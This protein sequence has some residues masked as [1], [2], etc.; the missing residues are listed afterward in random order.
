MYSLIIESFNYNENRFFTQTELYDLQQAK[1]IFI[2]IAQAVDQ[3]YLMTLNSSMTNE[4]RNNT[5][6]NIVKIKPFNTISDAETFSSMLAHEPSEY[7]QSIRK[8][9][10][11]NNVLSKHYIID[12][13]NNVVKILSDCEEHICQ[14]FNGQCNSSGCSKVEFATSL[15]NKKIIPITVE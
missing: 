1:N 9:N 2:K 7:R 5:Y 14:R 10:S 12:N 6:V 8:W 15:K 4:I 11:D 3:K 13:K